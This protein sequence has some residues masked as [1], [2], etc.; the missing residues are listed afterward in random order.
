MNILLTLLTAGTVL[1]A[2]SDDEETPQPEKTY[3]MT[4]NAT[5]QV[6]EDLARATRALN[7]DDT[8]VNAEW[9]TTDEVYVEVMLKSGDKNWYNGTLSPQSNGKETQLNGR[10]SKPTGWELTFDEVIAQTFKLTLYF[11]CKDKPNYAEGQDGTLETIAANYDYAIADD[12]QYEIKND[13]IE[14]SR[15][16][17]FVNQQAIVKFTLNDG[18]TLLKPL[19]LTIEIGNETISLTGMDDETYRANEGDGV[20]F[21]AI[22]EFSDQ[23]VTLTAT[24][25]SDTYTCT[26]ND[27]TFDNGNYYEINVKMNKTN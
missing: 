21:V 15:Y 10:L 18:T 16:A 25:G 23:P 19:A 1:T 5:K 11:P 2:C 8:G 9:R 12:V 7:L 14:G 3:Y 22:P 6:N 24:V 17:T 13:H 27:V 20:L 4:I 26:Q